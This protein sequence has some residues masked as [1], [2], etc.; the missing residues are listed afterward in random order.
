[1]KNFQVLTAALLASVIA[2]PCAFAQ[3]ASGNSQSNNTTQAA[4]NRGGA[5]VNAVTIERVQQQL[6]RVGYYS[7]P[8]DGNWNRQTQQAL[9]HFQRAHGIMSNG[10]IN[11]TSLLALGVGVAGPMNDR[12]INGTYVNGG[13]VNPGYGNNNARNSTWVD[14]GAMAGTNNNTAAVTHGTGNGVGTTRSYGYRAGLNGE[15]S[16]PGPSQ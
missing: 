13:Y 7:G 6:T 12:Q 4:T 10:R 2:L 9:I 3:G 15:Y 8:I 5:A 16:P 11:E 14:M 1:M